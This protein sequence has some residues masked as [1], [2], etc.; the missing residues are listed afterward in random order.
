MRA[1]LL[2]W[3]AAVSHAERGGLGRA[4][5]ESLRSV[6][7]DQSGVYAA[8]KQAAASGEESM[9]PPMSW[10][11]WCSRG[12]CGVAAPRGGCGPSGW[13]RWCS[14]RRRGWVGRWRFSRS[15]AATSSPVSGWPSGLS[16][17]PPSRATPR[18][19]AGRRCCWAWRGEA[20]QLARIAGD[21]WGQVEALQLLAY[22]H[23]H[24]SDHAAACV[25]LDSAMPALE[26]L[27]HDQLR[28]WDAAA[29]AEVAIQTGRVSL[30]ESD[31]RRGLDLARRIRGAG[32]RRRRPVAVGVGDAGAR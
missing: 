17:R 32:Q 29:R 7:C 27:G 28:A 25:V 14:I 31:G 5:E 19:R 8:L 30:A 20:A 13:P 26:R 1:R 23:L 15:T 24:R 16:S 10:W 3:V 4:D 2:S 9:S 6:E 18:C 12:R 22:T 11:R 21:E